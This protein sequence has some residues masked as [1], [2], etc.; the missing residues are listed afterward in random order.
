MYLAGKKYIW[1]DEPEI[2]EGLKNLLK[3]DLM[4]N[5]VSFNIIT[6]RKAN[7]IHKWFVDNCQDGNDD[8]KEYYVDREQLEQLL[9]ILN[10]ILGK[11]NNKKENIMAALN[12]NEMAEELLPSTEGHF[13]GGEDYDEYYFEY[14]KE[15][16][17]ILNDIF[18]NPTKYEGIEFY[19][20]ASW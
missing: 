11:T 8:C 2:K 9:E 13:F 3:T 16:Q 5:E 20:T 19:Y 14:L 10:K 4:P 15:T 7:A 1:F 17:R 12:K 18:E 6:W